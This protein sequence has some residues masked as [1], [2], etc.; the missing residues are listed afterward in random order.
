LVDLDGARDGKL[1]NRQAVADIVS[2]VDVPCQLGGGVRD[3]TVIRQLL[4][5]GLQRLV[6]GSRALHEPEWFVEMCRRFPT[7]LVLGVDARDGRVA[8]EG[9]RNTSSQGAVEFAQRFQDEPVAA[10]VYTDIARD[11][12]MSGPNV[13]A[14]KQMKEQVA[15]PIVASGGVTTIADVIALANVPV[16]GAIIGRSLYQS[17]ITLAD[18]HRAAAGI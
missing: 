4:E 6:I 9:W 12:M 16:D 5:I 14:T 3:E 2:A 18:A 13:A 8:T 15:L 1:S 10:V 17:T 11:G 7:K